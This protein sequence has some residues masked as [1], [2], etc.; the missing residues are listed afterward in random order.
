M[1]GRF[2]EESQKIIVLSK[3]EMK[4]LMHPYVGTEHLLLSILKNDKE[5]SDR[6]KKHNLTYK[7]F[8]DELINIVGKGSEKVNN[9]VFTPL[10]RLILES[11]TVESKENESI[12]QVQDL[13]FTLLNSKEGIA[14][15]VL[16]SLNIDVD[17]IKNELKVKVIK[18]TN[19][20]TLLDSLATDF[21]KMKF[22]VV[23]GRDE[24]IERLIEVLSRKNKCNP[25]L[26]GEAGVGKTAIVE[27]LS[28]RISLKK[29]PNSLIN[30]K[31]YSLDMA[32]SVAGT[33][34]RGEF[35]DRIKKIINELENNEN[36]IL[37]I[38]EVHTLVG[39]GG[40]EGA[41][42][43][44]NIFKPALAR[45]TLKIIGATTIKEYKKYIEKDSA[46]DRRFQKIYV[47]EPDEEKLK[48]ILLNLKT[49]YE[50][51]HNVIISNEV[52]DNI[53]NLSKKYIYDRFEPDKSIDI[54]DEVCAKV[55]LKELKIEKDLISLESSLREIKEKKN[56]YIS[57]NN[58]DRA[59]YYK[60]KEN[61]LIHRIDNLKNKLSENKKIKTVSINDVKKVISSK[62]K[63][64]IYEI[65]N[66]L[67][68]MVKIMEK[69][70]KDNIIGQECAVNSLIDITKKIKLGFKDKCYSLLLCGPTGVGKTYI[71]KIFSETLVG[72]NNVI[73]IDMGEY[74][75]S[76][77]INKLIGSPAGYI[78]Y[79]DN[80]SILE[81]I[82]NKPFSVL[83]LD[84]IEKCN[85]RVLNFF[86]NILDEG[87]CTLA[88]GNVIRFDNVVIIMTSNAFISKKT[89]GFNNYSLNTLNDYFSK[90]FLNRIDEVI[91]FDKLSIRDIKR[92][93]N[94]E[95][96][97]YI[98]KYNLKDSAIKKI[99]KKVIK[100]S[101]YEEYGARKLCKMIRNNIEKEIIGLITLNT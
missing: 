75:D 34:Y 31:I 20:K 32:T 58:L 4:K 81:E 30:K 17:K 44:S 82:R 98:K 18:K 80:K 41:I 69:R 92:I 15:R 28:R 67:N 63:I 96:L 74:I 5:L 99:E 65:N 46:L 1:F 72:K 19:K 101:N 8:R 38:D 40:A 39:A 42:D 84:E 22:D 97:K 71:S 12:V 91:S 88:N 43:A 54:L 56:K 26:I 73:K 48:D 6:L 29:V 27:E 94:K 85:K 16:L 45:G 33:K 89:V 13:L 57:L 49:S 37:F 87:K 25:L 53:I 21:S 47:D 76:A 93:Y 11:V 52:I 3:E 24:E 14:Y 62:S 64:P 78:G 90:E 95:V 55:S 66:D 51:Y 9:Y 61:N 100:D 83:I 50:K 10:Y 86:L 60:D 23:T 35:E 77:S 36:I 59:Y 68:K 7:V 70:L 2:S 79:D